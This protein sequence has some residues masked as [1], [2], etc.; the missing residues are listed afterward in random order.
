VDDLVWI[1]PVAAI[2]GG[3]LLV[4]L[5]VRAAR[6]RA[7]PSSALSDAPPP[8]PGERAALEAALDRAVADDDSARAR[9]IRARLRV[10]DYWERKASHRGDASDARTKKRRGLLSE[11]E[12]ASKRFNNFR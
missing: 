9:E 6:S 5:R 12:I 8:E 2:A 4:A 11:A 3:A 10:L 7:A 1:L